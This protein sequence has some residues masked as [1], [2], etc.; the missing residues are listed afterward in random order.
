MLVL[1]RKLREVIKI[2]GDVKVTVVAIRK[3]SISLG[4]EAPRGVDIVREE[5]E[6]ELDD[7]DQDADRESAAA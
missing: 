3:N 6:I 4:I 5:L 1:T 7:D 2:G